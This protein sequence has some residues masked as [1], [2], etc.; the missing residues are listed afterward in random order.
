MSL[1]RYAQAVGAIAAT[2]LALLWPFAGA[3]GERGFRAAALGTGLA[4]LNTLA[5]Y[6]L[7]RW[8]R[9]WPTVAFFRAILG[10]TLVRMAVLLLAVLVALRGAGLP[11]APLV[12]CLL[13][14]FMAF[15]ALET[16]TVWRPV[17]RPEPR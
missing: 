9:E 2:S 5:A 8:S 12:A 14:H 17:P 10:G 7:V 11:A 13:G 3:L 16:A 4:V 15:L 1:G 6:A